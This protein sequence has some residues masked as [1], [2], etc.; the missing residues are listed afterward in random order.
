M[1]SYETFTNYY[2]GIKTPKSAREYAKKEKDPNFKKMF[3]KLAKEL[4]QG[5]TYKAFTNSS[6]QLYYKK[7]K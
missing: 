6:G 2:G 1:V 5:I 3:L 4:E 7:R